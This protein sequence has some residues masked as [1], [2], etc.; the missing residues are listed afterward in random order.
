MMPLKKQMQLDA[1][2]DELKNRL[3]NVF[4]LCYLT[5]AK[6]DPN[7]GWVPP[8]PVFDELLLRLWHSHYKLTIDS[9]EDYR[10]RNIESLRSR[11]FAAKWNRILDFIEFVAEN[12]KTE[13]MNKK[14][15][16]LCNAVFEEESAG[17]RFVS[18]KITEITS[19]TEI[20][21]IEKAQESPLEPMNTHFRRSLELLSDRK[22]P[23][24]RNS[25]KESV[26][27][28]EALFK[29]LSGQPS[30]TL[31]EALKSIPSD[32]CIHPA[33]L[34]AFSSLYGY[35]SSSEGIRHAMLDADKVKPE[36][37]R[38]FLITCSAFANY[39]ISKAAGT[40]FKF[41]R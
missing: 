28:L 3:W 14:F 24:Y 17:Y 4:D 39:M 7:K 1:I 26:L 31:G 21:E 32:F 37:A 29:V 5:T 15:M 40:G 30:S 36:D 19:R 35:T 38:Y 23:D 34:K 13:A 22:N 10:P 9:L 11:F 41:T 27:A 6:V 33:L 12:Y 18:G 8:D 20:E 25:I 2:D 16:G